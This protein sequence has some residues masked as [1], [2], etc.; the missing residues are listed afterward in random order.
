MGRSTVRLASISLMVLAWSCLPTASGAA[1]VSPSDP[2]PYA[3]AGYAVTTSTA[4]FG[5]A[6]VFMPDGQVVYGE[7][8]GHGAGTQIYIANQNGTDRSCLTCELKAPNNVPAVRPEGDWILFHSWLGHDITLG[9]PGYGGLGSALWVMRPNGSDPTQLTETQKGF[10]A[11]EGYDDYHAYWSPDGDQVVWAHLN[12][13]FVDGQGQGKWDIRVANFTVSASGVPSL[14]DVRV[15]RPANG[16]WYETQWWAPDGSG[17][18]YTQTSGTALDTELFFCRLT[19]S[20]CQVTQLTDSASWNEQAIF[21]PDGQDVI[22]MSSRD[23]PGFFNTLVQLT[24]DAD[25]TTSEDYLLILEVFEAS[26]EQPVAQEATDLYELD[27]ATG[28]VR[29]LT[30]DG[31]AGWVTPE[32]AWNPSHTFLMW[33]EFRYPPGLRVPLPLNLAVQVQQTAQFLTH[34]PLSSITLPSSNALQPSLPLQTRTRIL[35]FNLTAERPAAPL[36]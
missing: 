24:K 35:R 14:T 27:L 6:P 25:L 4:T 9:S 7:D 30:T 12:W 13:N 26:Y 28:S 18:L 15:V 29:R 11:D 16:S 34:P 36:T 32:F 1:P 22:F 23:H 19:A 2:N 33:T 21:T 8:L 10:G 20:G 5:Q 17:F 3:T 31:D